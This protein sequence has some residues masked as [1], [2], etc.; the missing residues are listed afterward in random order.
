VGGVQTGGGGAP[1]LKIVV[2][3]E[4]DAMT[5]DAQG[6]APFSIIFYNL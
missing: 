1:P 4:A 6:F 3:D 2:L 5:R